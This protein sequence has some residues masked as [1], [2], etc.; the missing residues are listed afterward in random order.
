ML[1]V[2]A[3]NTRST[4]GSL[5]DLAQLVGSVAVLSNDAIEPA[6]YHKSGGWNRIDEV[7]RHSLPLHFR[8]FLAPCSPPQVDHHDR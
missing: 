8:R 6:G 3:A 4:A 7:A 1:T 2:R 5:T